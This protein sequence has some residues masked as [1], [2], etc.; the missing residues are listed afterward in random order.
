MEGILISHFGREAAQ[1]RQ[2][3]E[4]LLNALWKMFY[5]AQASVHQASQA[6]ICHMSHP[7]RL[8]CSPLSPCVCVLLQDVF[9]LWLL[10]E[11]LLT[12]PSCATW[13]E[14]VRSS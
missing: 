6:C 9:N 2:A 4:R 12:V 7:C 1:P 13:C 3:V 8:S 10:M 11:Q 14:I 5:A